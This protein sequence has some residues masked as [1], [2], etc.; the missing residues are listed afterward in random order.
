MYF[1]ES[2]ISPELMEQPALITRELLAAT[3]TFIVGLFFSNIYDTDIH[4]AS[5]LMGY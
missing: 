5:T 2:L 4:C 3:S 1:E